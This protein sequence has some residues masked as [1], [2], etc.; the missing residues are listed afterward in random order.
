MAAWQASASSH[1]RLRGYHQQPRAG[2]FEVSAHQQ[3]LRQ[4]H[5]C[6]AMVALQLL[7]LTMARSTAASG[8]PA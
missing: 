3:R 1:R 2:L 7:A 6:A 8:S 4:R 5:Q